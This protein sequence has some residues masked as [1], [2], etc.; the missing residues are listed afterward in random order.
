MNKQDVVQVAQWLRQAIEG[1]IKQTRNVYVENDMC[2]CAVAA[3]YFEATGVVPFWWNENMGPWDVLK[4]LNKAT[5]I[6]FD[7]VLPGRDHPLFYELI[8]DNDLHGA[9]F[10]ALAAGLEEISE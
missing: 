8:I 9:S 10:L 1:G 7:T 5:G 2:M 4:T 3:I 6:D